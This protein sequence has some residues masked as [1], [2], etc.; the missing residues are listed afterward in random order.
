MSLLTPEQIAVLKE[1]AFETTQAVEPRC[2]I[3]LRVG[4]ESL[5]LNPKQCTKIRSESHVDH[6]PCNSKE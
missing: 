6:P 4:Q 5:A 1:Q 3:R 2:N